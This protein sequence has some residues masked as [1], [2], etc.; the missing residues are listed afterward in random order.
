MTTGLSAVLGNDP[1]ILSGTAFL[2]YFTKAAEVSPVAWLFS[3]FASC[4]TASMLLFVGLFLVR[5]KLTAGNP[6]NVVLCEGFK[7][8]YLAFTAYTI[9]PF[10]ACS[11]AALIALYIQFWRNHIPTR[12]TAPH[13]DPKGVLLD[14]VGA[15]V[16]SI[17][18]LVT[19]VVITGTG[20]AGTY[21][22]CYC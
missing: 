11:V 4:N 10:L 19:L 15:I 22:S 9:F 18:L 5:F 20:F 6:T 14:P 2:V 7:I 16:G 17:A 3:E 8:N 13:V 1:V 12:V 21:L